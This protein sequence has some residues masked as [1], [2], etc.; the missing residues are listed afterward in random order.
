MDGLLVDS[1]RLWHEAEVEIL[2]AL[3]VPIARDDVRRTKGMF[4]REVTR[5]WH[6]RYPWHGPTTEE[7]AVDIVDRVIELVVQKGKLMPGVGTALGMCRA[8]G[9][10][11]GVASSSEYRLVREVLSR[12]DLTRHFEVVHSA[13]DEQFGKPHPAVFLT[14]AARLAVAPDRCIVWEDAPAGVIA[15]KAARMTC[16]AVPDAQDRDQPAFCIADAVLGSLE[17]AGAE[18]WDELVGARR[19]VEAV[20]AREPPAASS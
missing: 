6:D 16:V 1:E 12:F 10:R 7:V 3:G 13:Q 15:A 20:G 5:F 17:E 18:L 2:G 11:L 9:L 4:V 14:T 19:S 8:H